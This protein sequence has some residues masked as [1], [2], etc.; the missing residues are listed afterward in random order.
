MVNENDKVKETI[1]R[2]GDKAEQL[3]DKAEEQADEVAEKAQAA[4]DK[5]TESVEQVREKTEEFYQ[6]ITKRIRENPYKSLAIAACTG[7][8]VALWCKKNTDHE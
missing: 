1:K 7:A 3:G 2:A 8:M 5:F 4:A 6:N